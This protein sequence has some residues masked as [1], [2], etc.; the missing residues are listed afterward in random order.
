MFIAVIVLKAQNCNM[1]LDIWNDFIQR[2]I[3]QKWPQ[4]ECPFWFTIGFIGSQINSLK[5]FEFSWA[6]PRHLFLFHIQHCFNIAGVL[7]VIFI[8]IFI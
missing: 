3:Y 7:C 1:S 4:Y 2:I 5:T 6:F 8:S